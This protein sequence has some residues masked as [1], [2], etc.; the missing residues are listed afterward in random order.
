MANAKTLADVQKLAAEAKKKKEDEAYKILRRDEPLRIKE[1]DNKIKLEEKTTRD[2]KNLEILNAQEGEIA[3]L[4]AGSKESTA[5]IKALG[6]RLTGKIGA[7][8]GGGMNKNML[9]KLATMQRL[10]LL[11]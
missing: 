11:G 8:G 6:K 10:G 9:V 5:A 4:D 1:R 2:R 7:D 3:K